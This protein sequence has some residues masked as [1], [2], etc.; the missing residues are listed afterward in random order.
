MLA[1]S[2]WVINAS[3]CKKLLVNVAVIFMAVEVLSFSLFC[4]VMYVRTFVVLLHYIEVMFV[5][6]VILLSFERKVVK[7]VG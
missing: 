3:R 6:V 7:A 5:I 4:V 2:Y 1:L